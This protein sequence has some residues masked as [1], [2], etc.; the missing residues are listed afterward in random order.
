M[1]DK[2]RDSDDKRLPAIFVSGTD[3]TIPEVINNDFSKYE[4]F[5]AYATGGKAELRS[6]RDVN[7]GR[8]VVLKSLREE[9]KDD[10]RELRRLV[11][12]ARITAQLQHPSTV[13]VYELGID[14]IGRFYFAMKQVAGR[15]LFNVIV[16][17]ARRVPAD[18]KEFTLDRRLHIFTQVGEAL[19]Y[20]HA[21]G[22][23]HRDIKPE[24]VLVGQFG[25]VTLL[26]WGSVKVWGMPNEGD[27]DKVSGRGGTP[28]Y[29][30]PEQVLGHRHLDER[31]DIFSM[32]VVL[33]EM[34]AQREPFRGQNVRSTFDNIVNQDPKRISEAAPHR[35]VPPRLEEVCFKAMQKEPR[36]RYGSMTEMVD[37]VRAFCNDAMLRGS[38]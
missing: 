20:A 15:S 7:L 6:C 32:G 33:Y 16:G 4:S 24:N 34:L 1:P 25:E 21:M 14:D 5:K 22:V 29:M 8:R 28:L 30:S 38:V 12:E 26:D 2:K 31:T 19:C 9:Y 27:D 37:E 36:D 10:A 23:I 11:R 3:S 17:L 18:E 13:P 35:E